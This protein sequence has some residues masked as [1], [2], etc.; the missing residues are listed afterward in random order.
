MNKWAK[1]GAVCYVLWGLI[2]INAAR[3]VYILGESVDPGMVQARIYQDAWLLFFIA[4][5]SI[6]IA[7]IYNWQNSRLGYWLN[8]IMLSV[9]DVGFIGLVLVPGYAPWMP[10]GLGPALW[11]LAVVFSSIGLFGGKQEL[12]AAET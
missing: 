11:L 7:I 5:A 1:I 12:Q 6:V 8:L 3:L 4:I 9:A 2:H 10:A